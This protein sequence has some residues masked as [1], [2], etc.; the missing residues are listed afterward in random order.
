LEGSA[1]HLEKKKEKILRKCLQGRKRGKNVQSLRERMVEEGKK[2]GW[3]A[4]CEK[5]EI[6]I[7]RDEAW[8]KGT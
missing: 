4:A 1:P 8:G 2:E 6:G 7:K 5:R 3:D